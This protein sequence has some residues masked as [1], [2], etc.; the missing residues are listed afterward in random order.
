MKTIILGLIYLSSFFGLYFLLSLFGLIW[1]DYYTMIS[2][3]GWFM[4]Y[5]VVI[6][7][8]TAIFPTREYY[9]KNKDVF[10]VIFN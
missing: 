7:W 2:Q 1:V 5:S 3:G 4:V 10:D 8:W 9:L 6:G